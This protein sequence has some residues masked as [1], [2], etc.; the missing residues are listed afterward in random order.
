MKYTPTI[1][2]VFLLLLPL[3]SCLPGEAGT[4]WGLLNEEAQEL[5]DKGHYA[6]AVVVTKKAL[7]VAEKNVGP[8]HPDVATILN[9]L[10][11]LYVTQGRHTQAEPLYKRALAIVG[12]TLGPDHPSVA[13]GLNN[14]ALLYYTQ[15]HYALAEPHYKRALA[16]W[17]KGARAGPP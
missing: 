7:E 16:I 13:M 1:I 11:E 12:K 8:H 10:A 5:H 4:E 15:G 9:N 17:E 6:R 2:T 14:L 3:P